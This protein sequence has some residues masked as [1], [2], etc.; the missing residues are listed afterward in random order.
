MDAIDLNEER[1]TEERRAEKQER[2]D[3]QAGI[4]LCPTCGRRV[5]ADDLRHC[6]GTNAQGVDCRR[7]GCR[8]CIETDSA[9]NLYC[10]PAC[11]LDIYR[12]L[13]EFEEKSHTKLMDWY[14]E[15]IKT[16]EAQL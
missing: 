9:G 6:D 10:C 5:A 16:L 11:G 2:A 12:E 8:Y 7:K 13:I 1:R 3:A 15:R 14:R 4:V